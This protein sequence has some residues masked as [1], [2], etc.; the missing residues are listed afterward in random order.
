MRLYRAVPIGT[1][2]QRRVAFGRELDDGCLVLC[3]D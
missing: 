2:M 1:L 3:P